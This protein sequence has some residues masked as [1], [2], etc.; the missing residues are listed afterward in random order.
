MSKGV[1]S[2]HFAGKSELLREVIGHVLTEAA[3]YMTPARR[4]GH[5]VHWTPCGST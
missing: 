4:G 3:A 5:L 2:Y 1:L